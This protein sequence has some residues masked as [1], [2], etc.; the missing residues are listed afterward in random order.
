MTQ[1]HIS[2]GSSATKAQFWVSSEDGYVLM[3]VIRIICVIRIL[4]LPIGGVRAH[5]GFNFQV[6]RSL[7]LSRATLLYI[8]VES[9]QSLVINSII[10]NHNTQRQVDRLIQ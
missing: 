8:D 6:T 3:A 4:L 9:K 1:V 10:M 2:I 7:L 5:L